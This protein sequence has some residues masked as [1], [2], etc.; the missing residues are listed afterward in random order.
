MVDLLAKGP[1]TAIIKPI[2]KVPQNSKKV[3]LYIG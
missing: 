1:I 3:Y 2:A